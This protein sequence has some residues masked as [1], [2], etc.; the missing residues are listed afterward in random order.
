MAT[1]TDQ[2][3]IR[4]TLRRHAL[5]E[6]PWAAAHLAIQC[7]VEICGM[8]RVVDAATSL[9]VFDPA[10]PAAELTD[11]PPLMGAAEAAA[12]LGMKTT[13]LKRLSPPLPV[14]ARISGRL[15]VYREADVMA[16]RERRDERRRAAL[17]GL[18]AQQRQRDREAM[19]DGS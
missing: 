8:E 17:H 15:P 16:A 4:S 9:L 14:A 18:R 10:E 7:A 1:P 5:Y 2:Q 19:A 12:M 11:L 3:Q 13:N 6:G